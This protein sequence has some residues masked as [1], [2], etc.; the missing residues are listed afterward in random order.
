VPTPFPPNKTSD[1]L[2]FN[3]STQSG[4]LPTRFLGMCGTWTRE[5]RAEGCV[6]AQW[7][8][9]SGVLSAQTA[10]RGRVGRD[11]AS[12]ARFW[13]A[14]GALAALP[15][16]RPRWAHCHRAPGRSLLF[17]SVISWV[18]AVLRAPSVSWPTS[19]PWYLQRE[20][21]WGGCTLDAAG[22]EGARPPG[23]ALCC[24]SESWVIKVRLLRAASSVPGSRA[25]EV[26]VRIFL[27]NEWFAV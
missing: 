1:V 7:P 2:V 10:L 12:P 8:C 14:T 27:L 5:G 20:L 25:F 23:Q 24:P 15:G 4:R 3:Y 18:T 6:L 22:R 13:A 26:G 11:R 19:A 16:G 21:F 9:G 17:G